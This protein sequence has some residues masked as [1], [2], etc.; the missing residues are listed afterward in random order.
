MCTSGLNLIT[1]SYTEQYDLFCSSLNGNLKRHVILS[2]LRVLPLPIIQ[3]MILSSP[4]VKARVSVSDR[5]LLVVYRSVCKRF[6]FP[7]SQEPE[8][9]FN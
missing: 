3:R 8:G 2:I 1:V 5:L 6:T 4:E 9:L 7:T